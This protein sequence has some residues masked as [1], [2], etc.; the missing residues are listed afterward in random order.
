MRIKNLWN[1]DYLFFM[2]FVYISFSFYTLY[3]E[4]VDLQ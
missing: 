1:I 2:E 3:I 4:M